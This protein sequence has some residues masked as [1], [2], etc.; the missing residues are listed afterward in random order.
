MNFKKIISLTLSFILVFTFI[1]SASGWTQNIA[2]EFNRVNIE[3]DGNK[4]T[5]DNILYNGTTYIPLRD[6][7]N[8]LNYDV[9][10][11]ETT[12]TAELTS[13]DYLTFYTYSEKVNSFCINAAMYTYILKTANGNVCDND[14]L[15]TVLYGDIT[16]MEALKEFKN[17][18]YDDYIY[19]YCAF[20][21]LFGYEDFT[22]IKDYLTDTK[23]YVDL[24]HII[25]E[26]FRENNQ[27]ISTKNSDI[28]NFIKLVDRTIFIASFIKTEWYE[29][30]ISKQ[31]K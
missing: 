25:I 5:A 28:A 17:A 24:I 19:L 14:F 7:S 2:V 15:D 26:N 30:I 21:N 23:D 10:W 31:A 12:D 3:I 4:V 9:S 11:N 13:N 6:T 1:S 27:N 16:A 22:D 29:T 8:M 18:L 20:P